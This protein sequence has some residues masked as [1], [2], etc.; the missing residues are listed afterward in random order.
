MRNHRT[1]WRRIVVIL[2]ISVKVSVIRRLEAGQ[3]VRG[4]AHTSA[5]AISARRAE[6]QA[7]ILAAEPEGI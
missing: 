5:R 4:L 1:L 3:P 7:D 6:H 2:R